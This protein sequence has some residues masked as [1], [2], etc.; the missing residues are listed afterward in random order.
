MK[1]KSIKFLLIL[2]SLTFSL[3]ALA[4]NVITGK[5][6]DSKSQEALP[7]ATVKV[8]GTNVATT[9]NA[10]GEYTLSVPNLNGK[11]QVSYIGYLSKVI[12]IS[13]R[14]K[15][16]IELEADISTLDDVVVIG[17]GTAKKSDI[18]GSVSS[19]TEKDFNKGV[20]VSAE[21]LIAGKV[22]G[23]QIVQS[24]GEPGGGI[25]VNIRGMGS[26]NAGNA[27]LY[28]VDGFPI[29]NSS[30]VSGTGANFTGMRT[31]RNP[32]NSI[33][34]NDIASI[35][36]LKDASATAIY[37]ARGANGVVLIT[38]KR[39][40]EGSLKVNY[41]QYYGVQNVMN[42]LELLNANQ[43]KDVMNSLI[44]AGAGAASLKVGEVGAGTDWLAR[45]YNKNA[46]INS[47]NLSF[48]GGNQSTKYHTSLNYFDQEGVLINSSNKRYSARI[49]L[50]HTHK[51]FKFG[52]NISSSYVAD[53]YVAN[54]MDLNERAGIIYAATM[55]EPI[56]SIYD[57]DNN[58]TL[59]R[60]MNVDNPL[61]IANGKTSV[62]NLYRTLGTVYGEMKF[63]KDFTARLNLGADIT[64]Q[65]RDTYVD[66]QTIEGRANGGIASILTGNNNSYLSELTLNYAKRINQ[67]DINVLFGT[68]AQQFNFFDQTSQGSGFP[69]DATK[70][71]NMS[72]GDPTRF[73][74]TS[75]RSRNSLLS[76]LGRANYNLSD[77][78]LFTASL[79]IDGSSRFGENNKYGIFPSFA[80]A[81]R[82]ENEDFIKNID[83]ISGL[84][85]RTSWGQTGNQAIGNYQSMTTYTSGQMAVIGNQQVSTTTPNRVPNPNLKWE[86]SEQLN[87]GLDYGLFNNRVTGSLD[88]FVKTTRD[89]LL[90]LPIPRTT[91]FTTM[92]TNV[93][94]VKNGG[95][96]VLVNS[97]NL[98]RGPLGWETTLNL[99]WLNNKVLDLGG[100]ENIFSG[101]AGGTS[102][103]SII[104]EGLPMY[105]FFGYVID[106]VWQEGD[107]FSVTNDKVS[108]GDFK[109]RDL[110]GDKIVNADD[111]TVLGSP[112]PNF[113]A[114]LTNN[115]T[116]K[117]FNLNIF[118]D[119]VWGSKMLNNNL[120]D[121]YFPANLMR[122]RLAEPML[123]RWTPSNPSNVYPSFITPLGQGKKEVNNY[124]VENA[125]YLRLNTVK[126]GYD[127]TIKN[128]VV[129]G[130]GVYVT[131]QNLAIWT[132]Y[133]GYDP[134]INP[135]GGGVRID[136]NAFPTAKTVLFGVNI[137]L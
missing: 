109:Y 71:D 61:A 82:L 44:D 98:T 69:S 3:N 77:K 134:S 114:S 58:Y 94:S 119:G 67:H 13:N 89:M 87:F 17:Y 112:F 12:N 99:T 66:R 65:R 21:Q 53:N 125:D 2:I 108:P 37:G 132:K 1:L 59:S 76:Y 23:V 64:S 20:N 85:L 8:E 91:G 127:F 79:R 92:M 11:I 121:T 62:S 74:V 122:N 78:Y 56:L 43:Y 47:H 63:L 124:T 19:V 51:N 123:N 45:M 118:F 40:K 27:P 111:R 26:L 96:E 80:F 106:G 110:N 60:N 128:S 33:N 39:G 24:S 133:K 10:D 83:Y 5:V 29:D 32:L 55:Y 107:D 136:W 131:G 137:N 126:L 101:S 105:S 9:S 34:P 18:T 104:K 129:K 31:A 35:E 113:M 16:D 36:V 86:T 49:N 57:Q 22:A 28:V 75:G 46:P 84:K 97:R 48:S 95:F 4:Q 50:E 120:V 88:W 117:G 93:G 14:S 70:T 73:I 6:M 100:V 81:Y 130:L 115:F 72:L 54:G 68:T 102:N 42:D 52:T 135:N 90:N 116:Y 38:T 103:V 30:T 25:N 15:I 41:D 7:G